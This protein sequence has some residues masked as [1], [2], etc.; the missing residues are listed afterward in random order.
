MKK[1]IGLFL[2]SR[3]SGGG[4]FQYNQIMI[5]AVSSL[6]PDRF[7]V[8]VGYTSELWLEYLR[9]HDVTTVPITRGYWGRALGLG[10]CLLGL[11]IGMWRRLSPL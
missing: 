11:P 5:D 3:P 2:E 8:V 7:S 9:G 1:K 4:T 6:P 10:W